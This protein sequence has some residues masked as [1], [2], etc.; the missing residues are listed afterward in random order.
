[1]DRSTPTIMPSGHNDKDHGCL[2]SSPPR[3]YYY[4]SRQIDVAYDNHMCEAGIPDIET[5]YLAHP[6]DDTTKPEAYCPAFHV[7]SKG[8]TVVISDRCF[9]QA[10]HAKAWMADRIRELIISRRNN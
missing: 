10:R 8:H 7:P 3:V 1:M 5:A 4:T 6:R 2:P 9:S